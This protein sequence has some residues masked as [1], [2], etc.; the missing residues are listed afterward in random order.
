MTSATVCDHLHE[1]YV[2][3]DTN[4]STAAYY[5]NICLGWLMTYIDWTLSPAPVLNLIPF[6]V[7]YYI[8]WCECNVA[9]AVF[10]NQICLNAS[11]IACLNMFKWNR[12][13]GVLWLLLKS[14]WIGYQCQQSG[15]VCDGP[16]FVI[17][18]S[19]RCHRLECL[20]CLSSRL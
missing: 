19:V 10:S 13:A 12:Y 4:L 18:L 17:L 16:L 5:I 3:P 20:S 14:I 9:C 8:W 7:V 1:R 6:L 15:N 11:A 2:L